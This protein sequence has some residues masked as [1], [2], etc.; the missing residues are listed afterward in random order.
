MHVLIKDSVIQIQIKEVSLYPEDVVD[1]LAQRN[2]SL[3][4]LDVAF[5]EQGHQQVLHQ[6]L[7]LRVAEDVDFFIAGDQ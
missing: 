7:A 4:G 6:R 3:V 5:L 2:H 1:G